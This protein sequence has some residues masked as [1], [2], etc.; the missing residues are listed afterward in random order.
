MNKYKN[1]T[2]TGLLLVL[3][4]AVTFFALNGFNFSD[5]ST[6]QLTKND[7][8]FSQV[9]IFVTNEQDESKMVNAGLLI[10]HAIRKPG[11]Y[12]DAWLSAAEMQMLQNSGVPFQ[13]LIDDWDAYYNSIN[14]PMTQEEMDG[15]MRESK[16]RFDVSHSIYGTMGGHL[17][18]AEAIAKIDSMRLQYPTLIS[19]KFSI[20]TTYESRPIWAVRITKNP[21]APTGRP[22]VLYHA[23]IHAR[24]PVSMAA[25]MYYFYWLFENYNIDPMATYILNNRE[26][27]WI[28][29]FNP[30]GHVYNETTNP[31][32]GGMWRTNRH[33]ISSGCGM[34][35][36]NR[37]F[38]IYAFWNSTNGGSSTN[39]CSGG[40]GTYRG[41][42]PFSELETQ[43]VMTFINGKQF[44][45]GLGA[46]TYGNYLIRPWAW[47]DSP[48]PDDNIFQEYSIDMTQYNHYTY[49]RASQTVGYQVRGGADDCYYNDSGHTK[50]I[51]MTPETG[52]SFWPT[53][54]Q[55]LPLCEGMLWTNQYIALV[56]GAYVYPLS[57]TFNQP[58]YNPGQSGTYKVKFRNKGLTTATNVKVQLV[59]W[60]SF[61]TIPTQQYN[62][63]SLPT[64]ASD[65]ATFSFTLA[66]NAPVNCAIPTTLNLKIDTSTVYTET[67]YIYVGTGAITLND[68]AESGIGNWTPTGGWAWKTDYYHSGT[69][70]FGYAPYVNNA[71]YSLTLTNPINAQ[72]APVC[73]LNFWNRYSVESGWDY[74]IVEVSSNNGTS[75]QQVISYTGINLTWTEQSFDITRFVNASTQLKIR[76]RLTSDGNTLGA[77]WWVDD[78]KLTNYC[79][80]LVGVPGNTNIPKTFALE[81]NYPNPFNPVTVIKFQIPSSEFVTVKVFDVLG[82]EVSVIVNENKEPG[83]YEAAFDGSNLASGLYFYRIEAGDFVE[84]K[85]M[86]LVK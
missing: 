53:Q 69:H 45:S 28:P 46:H 4:A 63:A 61:V 18:W 19:Q 80:G 36:L 47:S 56:A 7:G 1:L 51:E 35:D 13:V 66:S 6:K 81:Q 39:Q 86:M 14:I 43:A 23:V 12:L 77:G 82:K 24:E 2:R 5:K 68:N 78:I 74:A 25:Q 84:T 40:Q 30:D 38:G 20:G 15:A 26:I 32:G 17:K 71:D 44:K 16:E 8:K 59:P 37:N 79:M 49:G 22:Q 72:S 85:K 70:S 3:I 52:A 64:F 62:F 48:T 55:I 57:K 60:N 21:D 42:S 50:M 31:N 73:Y 9:R 29:Y 34:V 83:Y 10:D 65:S 67:I 75:W 54:A 58:N 11:Q 27:Y 76:F 41:T 33:V